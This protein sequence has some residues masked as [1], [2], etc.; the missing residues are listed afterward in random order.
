MSNIFEIQP[1]PDYVYYQYREDMELFF[2]AIDQII[3]E[4]YFGRDLADLWGCRD[5]SNS[6]STYM[7]FYSRYYLGLVRPVRI[8]PSDFSTEFTSQNIINKYDTALF[9]DQRFIWDDFGEVSPEI[10]IALFIIMLRFIY[11]Y[12]EVTWTHDLMI[13]YTAAMCNM[14]PND[15]EISFERDKVIYW[16]VN[17]STC[18]SFIEYTKTDEYKLNFPYAN[19]YEYRIG[20]HRKNTSNLDEFMLGYMR[21]VGWPEYEKFKI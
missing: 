16:L 3:E 12:G 13:R 18:R 8:D 21:P 10:P 15:I 19:C 9:W 1:E 2:K 6:N 17:S 11:H 4:N 20:T 5:L 14:S 7:Y